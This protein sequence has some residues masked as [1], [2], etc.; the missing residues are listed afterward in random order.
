LLPKRSEQGYIFIILIG[1]IVELAQVQAY[2]MLDSE[3]A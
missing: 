1:S 3:S 2:S